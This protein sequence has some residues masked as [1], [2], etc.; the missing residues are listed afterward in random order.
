MED[1]HLL[2][3]R[4]D[5]VL[6][7]KELIK[8]LTEMNMLAERRLLQLCERSTEIKEE[9]ITLNLKFVDLCNRTSQYPM[10]ILPYEMFGDFMIM[11]HPYL[12]FDGDTEGWCHA[13]G[14][15]A[16]FN[17]IVTPP[18]RRVFGNAQESIQEYTL[19]FMASFNFRTSNLDFRDEDVLTFRSWIAKLYEYHHEPLHGTSGPPPG[20]LDLSICAG[21]GMITYLPDGQACF[22]DSK[23]KVWDPKDPDQV[24]MDLDIQN[25]PQRQHS[26]HFEP[27]TSS[28]Q[29]VGFP[30]MMDLY[31]SI[32]TVCT[33]AAA[34]S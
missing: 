31:E 29:A 25:S 3:V 27:G 17:S 22:Q 10:P 30:F 8:D 28:S 12:V 24:I 16:R 14:Q 26:S 23:G 1:Y 20:L 6:K 33:Y 13:V 4:K 11:V 7:L 2:D 5:V 18:W 32:Q 21:M 34:L 9:L 19:E 15:Q